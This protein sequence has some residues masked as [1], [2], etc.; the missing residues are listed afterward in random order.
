MRIIDRYICLEIL[1][2]AFLGLV[3]CTFVFFVPQLVQMMGLVVRHTGSIW[4]IARLFV[5]AFPGVLSFS[6]PIAA[7]VGVLIG[8]GRMSADSEL[9]AMNALGMGWRRLLVPIGVFATAAFGATLAMT[10]WLGPASIHTMRGIEEHMRASQASSEVQP[11]VFD[12]RFPNLVL[13]VQDVSAAATH[14]RGVFLAEF[15]ADYVSRLTLADEA[16]VIADREQGKLELHLRDGSVHDYSLRD[17]NHYGLSAFAQR[18]LS[19]AL[20]NAPQG[21]ALALTDA[22]RSMASLR[23]QQGLGAREA[24]VEYQRRLAFPAACLVFA[25]IALP[26]G[27]RPRR[28]GRSSGFLTAVAIVCGYYLIFT[29]GAGM[30]RDGSVPAWVGI[31]AANIAMTAIGLALLPR[32]ERMHDEGRLHHALNQLTDWGHWQIS[33]TL[34]GS[35]APAVEE[36]KD[37]PSA[38]AAAHTENARGNFYPLAPSHAKRTGGGFPQFLDFYLLRNFLFYFALL[39]AGFILLFEVFT[40]FD[41]LNDIARH[42]TGLLEVLNYFRL[43]SCYLFYQLAPLACLVAIL[44]TLGVMTKNNELV[45]FKAAG[46]SLYRIALPLVGI[47]IIF[48]AGLVILDDTYLPYANQRQNELRNMIKGNPAQ[49]YFRPGQQ[50]I[51]G[52]SGR[53][54]G[55][56]RASVLAA[57]D[58]GDKANRNAKIYNYQLFDPDRKL[59]GDLSVFELDPRTFSLRRRVYAAR[60]HWEPQ[61]KAWILESGWIR[62]FENG[63]MTNYLPFL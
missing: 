62:D 61:Q 50:W 41:L 57:S 36:K 18:D 12:E 5:S 58:S 16:I 22:E 6:L 2:A 49:T 25:F 38:T 32:I 3:I 42:R 30:A 14:W 27:S 31:W 48:A 19:V 52:D 45:A 7:L 11:R 13:Y 1:S 10:L 35:S 28:G 34:R 56:D 59:F 53:N 54:S 24:Q 46:V 26:V 43:L 55:S 20:N 40:F 60:A 47:G 4:E 33:R 39:L 29:V 17:P 44:V 51:F 21:K 8:L 63:H 37:A 15:G 23:Q 9:I